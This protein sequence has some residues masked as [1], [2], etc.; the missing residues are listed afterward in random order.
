MNV[1]FPFGN[2]LTLE[3]PRLK[4]KIHSY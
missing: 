1:I 2:P 3:E 4:Y